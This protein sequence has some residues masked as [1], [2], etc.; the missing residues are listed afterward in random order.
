MGVQDEITLMQL[1]AKKKG[2]V[3]NVSE[4]SYD[5]GYRCLKYLCLASKRVVQ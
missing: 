4:V 1:M 3:I 5:I 2:V